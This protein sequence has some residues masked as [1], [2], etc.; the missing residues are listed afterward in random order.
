MNIYFIENHLSTSEAKIQID[1]AKFTKN[2]EPMTIGIFEKEQM[3]FQYTI[4]RFLFLNLEKDSK[5]EVT[6]YLID[7]NNN[8][9][10]MKINIK[11]YD[12]D[13]DIFIYD[14][15]FNSTHKKGFKRID[16]PKS[17]DLTHQ[18]QFNYY[19]NLL[20]NTLKIMQNSEE[21][22]SLILSTQKL[23]MIKGV[24][25]QF[26]FYLSIFLQCFACRALGSHLIIFNPDKI[27]ST[28]EI[29]E[30]KIKQ[31]NNIINRKGNKHLKYIHE[32][33]EEK[34]KELCYTNF[35]TIFLY[36]NHLFN[37]EK[38]KELLNTKEYESNIY[39]SL[40]YYNKLFEKDILSDEQFKILIERVSNYN[41]LSN[42]LI[43][44]HGVLNLFQ[45]IKENF[46]KIEE[47]YIIAESELKNKFKKKNC[48]S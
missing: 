15:R 4:F 22:I 48:N 38:F 7:K 14:F 45:L 36:F 5:D 18:E 2:L 46:G 42:A 29:N 9:F 16:P 39:N 44:N 40:L 3:E 32:L 11:D 13:R 19:I 1:E 43:Y 27:E 20:R 6:I 37:E 34:D 35:Y 47:L 41:Q 21:N 12:R 30:E 10:K 33:K 25:Y 28:G 17:Y 8:K 23:L 26:S 24:K 31:L